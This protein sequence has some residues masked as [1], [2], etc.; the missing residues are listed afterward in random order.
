MNKI[1]ERYRFTLET[2]KWWNIR[3]WQEEQYYKDAQ[4]TEIQID[5]A[6]TELINVLDSNWILDQKSDNNPT[7]LHPLA[8]LLL[9]EGQ[10][11]FQILCS[12]GLDLYRVRKSGL[13]KESLMRRIKNPKEYWESAAFELQL[14]SHFLYQNFDIKR[15]YKSGKGKRGNCNCDFKISKGDEIIFLEAKRP[16]DMHRC[17]EEIYEKSFNSFKASILENN[18]RSGSFIGDPLLP[19][20]ELKKIFRHILYAANYQLPS[21][22]AGGVII[23]SHWSLDFWETFKEMANKRF[24]N[25]AKYSHLSFIVAVESFFDSQG[26]NHNIKILLNPYANIDVSSYKVLSAIRSLNVKRKR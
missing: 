20:P 21:D 13:L 4:F 10:Y 19:K 16:K 18:S 23:E 1:L 14:L 7:F 24:L 25:R 22:G 3:W 9:A 12:L 17:N 5:A 11:S 15:D 26:F 8:N 6:F 2:G